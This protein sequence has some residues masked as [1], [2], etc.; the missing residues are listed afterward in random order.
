[1][2]DQR[3]L[4]KNIYYMLAYAFQSLNLLD[5]EKIAVEDFEHVHDLFAA[6]LAR[7]AS[8]QL[9]QGLWRTYRNERDDL[10]ALR[11]KIDLERTIQNR[12][13][14]TNRIACAYD[15]LSENNL[16]NQIVKTTALLL[17]RHGDVEKDHRQELRRA[18]DYFSGVDLIDPKAVSWSRIRFNRGNRSYRLL[19]GICQLVLEGMLLTTDRG[20]TKLAAFADDQRMSRL[21]EKFLLEYYRQEHPELKA[22]AAR[23]PWALDDGEDALLP[24]L[25]SD[26]LL[27]NP[28]GDR[29]LILDAKYYRET[30][31]KGRFDNRTIHSANLYQIFTYVKNQD[32]NMKGPHTVSG[33][34][35]Y[36]K[37]DEAI[38][39]DQRYRMSGNRI[40]VKTLDLNRDFS[41]IR[42]QLD[43]IAAEHLTESEASLTEPIEPKT[44]IQQDPA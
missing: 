15:E 41:E 2:K 40:D 4:I 22:R 28:A 21:Y 33:M 34:L 3:I 5:D 6:I 18:V 31:A 36:A 11:G 12:M 25:Q 13:R 16:F 10:S 32:A 9:K 38:Q 14:Q 23:I 8:R 24:A 7:G 35:L 27:E 44:M 43:Q 29:V 30:L 19:L 20:E 39:P 17:L 1:M 37:T 26:I 42:V